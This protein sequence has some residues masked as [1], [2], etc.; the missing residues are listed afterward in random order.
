MTRVV[1]PLNPLRLAAPLALWLIVVLWAV[2]ARAT[3][4]NYSLYVLGVAAADATLTVETAPAAYRVEMRYH[5]IGIAD[6]FRSDTLD[7]RVRGRFVEGQP[8]PLEYLSNSRLRGQD[9]G[10]SIT[11][12]DAMPTVHWI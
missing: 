1:W 12:R 11:W 10:V 5:T 2:G 7:T 8:V 4:G 6:L 9:R 3:E